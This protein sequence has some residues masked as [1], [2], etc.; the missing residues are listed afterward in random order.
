M[1]TAKWNCTYFRCL[2][3]V[4]FKLVG[5][6]FYAHMHNSISHHHI[7]DFPIQLLG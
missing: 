2:C 7:K 3:V 4:H 6:S 5:G 1:K